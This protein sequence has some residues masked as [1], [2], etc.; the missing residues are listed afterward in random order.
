MNSV[1]FPIGPCVLALVVVAMAYDLHAR[2][3]PNW[4]VGAALLAALPVQVIAH[5]LPL[6][7]IWWLTGAL[8]G[9]V[10]L[11]PG[12]LM[13]WLG[14]G[15]VKLMTAVGALMGPRGALEAVLAG[16]AVGG[17]L[18]LAAL[19]QK[20]RVRRGLAGAMS[21]LITMAAAPGERAASGPKAAPGSAVASV[22]SLPY[23][24]AIAIGSVITLM[25]NA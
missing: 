10:L 14:A 11:I 18:S 1:I 21:I 2:R 20:R 13:R 25:V 9:G 15:D 24:V 7:P 12:Y 23:G 17:L 22:G 4:L 5:G 6:A 19:M 16:A 8:I 3:I